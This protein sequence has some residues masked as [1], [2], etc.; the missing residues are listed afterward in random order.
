MKI[1]SFETETPKSEYDLR[2]IFELTDT[3]YNK[4]DSMNF[5]DVNEMY[6]HCDAVCVGAY[7]RQ[8]FYDNVELSLSGDVFNHNDQCFITPEF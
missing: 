7:N 8:A 2:V 1:I 6:E 4:L 5:S 3:E